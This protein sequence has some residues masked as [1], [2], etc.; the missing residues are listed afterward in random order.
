V[1][2]GELLHVPK[3]YDKISLDAAE[4]VLQRMALD[5]RYL[6]SLHRFSEPGDHKGKDGSKGGD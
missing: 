4:G 1:D 2:P 6:V 3:L 5:P